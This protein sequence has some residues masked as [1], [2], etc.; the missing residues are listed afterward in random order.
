MADTTCATCWTRH[1]D[2]P[3]LCPLCGTP[4]TPSVRLIRHQ[5]EMLRD[6]DK[7]EPAEWNGL[8]WVL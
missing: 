6:C 2:G 5:G 1:P 3:A 8:G 7:A 4:T